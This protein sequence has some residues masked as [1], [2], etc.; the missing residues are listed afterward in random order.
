MDPGSEDEVVRLV[1]KHLYK[2]IFENISEM[3]KKKLNGNNSQRD[4]RNY[5]FNGSVTISTTIS[6]TIPFQ[7]ALVLQHN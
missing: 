1:G 3:E 7:H 6:S 2:T 5:T 4:Q